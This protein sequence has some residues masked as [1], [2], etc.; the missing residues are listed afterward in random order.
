MHNSSSVNSVLESYVRMESDIMQNDDGTRRRLVLIYATAVFLFWASLYLYVPTLPV[1]IQTKTTSLTMVGVVISMYGLWQ[2]VARLPLGIAADW[3]GRRKPFVLVCCL[4]SALGAWLM[5]SAG[6]VNGMIVGRGITG[7]AAAGWV[8]L[9]VLFSGLFPPQQA[10]RASAILSM[11]NSVSR[12]TATAMTGLLND[13]GGY[14]LAFYA[15]MFVAALALLVIL[16]SREDHR[17]P[18]KPSPAAIGRLIL[19]PE[20]LI[21]SL[22]GA[23]NQ[24]A[25]FAT[26]YG[27]FPILAK[28]L[29]A[30]NFVQGGMATVNL[31]AMTIG[32]LASTGILKRFHPA[33]LV[34]VSFVIYLVGIGIAAPAASLWVVLAAQVLTG[35]AS[36]I[37]YPILMGMSIQKVADEERATT[38]GVFQSVYAIGMF[39]GP[40]L[41]GILADWMGIPPMLAVTAVCVGGLGL[42]GTRRLQTMFSPL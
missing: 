21:P 13:W 37:G 28:N 39:G 8:P 20:V 27:F 41:S 19:R 31:A 23:V 9:V 12:M 29:G 6:D 18:Q 11:V 26:T 32:N 14:N 22:L 34:S 7:L 24:Y 38:M 33:Q 2:G 15:S 42:L 30:N 40:W 5:S 4:C 25:I 10:V 36:G 35:L 3:L 17:P 16:P 1:Y